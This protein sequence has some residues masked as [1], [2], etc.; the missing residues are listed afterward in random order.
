V[1]TELMFEGIE[2]LVLPGHLRS[3]ARTK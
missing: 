3:A 1:L 2:R